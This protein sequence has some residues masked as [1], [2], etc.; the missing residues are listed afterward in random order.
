[1]KFFKEK[2]LRVVT[3]IPKGTVMTYGEVA[4]HAGNQKASRVVGNFMAK[5]QDKNIPCH[6]VVKSDGG[7]G[8]YN[9]LCG[10]S[11][12]DLL[13]KEGVNFLKNGKIDIK[14]SIYIL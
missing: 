3:S 12:A 5:N 7:V 13:K 9:G 14:A 6:R 11:K 2:V 4:K 8:M 1:M 10:E